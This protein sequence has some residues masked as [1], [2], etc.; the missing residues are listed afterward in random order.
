[1][2]EAAAAYA[3][4][5]S[6]LA[7][8]PGTL[9]QPPRAI[10]MLSAHWITRGGFRIGSAPQPGMV[11]DYDGF[12]PHTYDIHYPAPG[13]PALADRVADLLSAQGI[14]LSPDPQRG[15]DHGAF[16]PAFCLYPEARVPMVQLSIEAGFNPATH[17]ALGVALRPLRDENILILGSGL[18]YHNL[19]LLGP[20]GRQPSADFDRWLQDTLIGTPA[21]KRRAGLLDWE[22]AP[23]ARIAHPMEDHFIPLLVAD[24][25]A[26]G[27]PAT[28]MH[29]E[30]TAFGGIT[31]SSFRYG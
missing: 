14:P 19:R 15:F 21:A 24:G 26:D 9:P 27:D 16:V 17:H 4:L 1:M 8:I 25:A 12:P 31:A 3:P 28:C 2:P 30:T 18:S 23:A 10:L 5:R 7:A 20:G 11:Y 29:H 22:H 13:S 6:A